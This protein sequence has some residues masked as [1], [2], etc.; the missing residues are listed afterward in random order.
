MNKRILFI[1]TSNARMG[2]GGKPTGV[3]AEELAAPYYAFVDSGADAIR[4]RWSA[5]FCREK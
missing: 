5:Q 3:W 2:E 4:T 1:T